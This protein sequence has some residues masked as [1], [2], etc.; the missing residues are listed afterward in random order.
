MEDWIGGQARKP[1]APPVPSGNFTPKKKQHTSNDKSA[2]QPKSPLI[3]MMHAFKKCNLKKKFRIFK[4]KQPRSGRGS[5]SSPR[6][7]TP[8]Q[9]SKTATANPAS[10][11]KENTEEETTADD[12]IST[13]EVS[14]AS[15]SVAQGK[16]LLVKDK[17]RRVSRSNRHLTRPLSATMSTGQ[18]NMLKSESETETEEEEED[19]PPETISWKSSE[20]QKNAKDAINRCTIPFIPQVKTVSNVPG[21]SGEK[22][23]VKRNLMSQF[24]NS[25][26]SDKEN[27]VHTI[28]NNSTWDEDDL[29][30]GHFI[31]TDNSNSDSEK[32]P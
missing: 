4:R 13:G 5:V 30:T 11:K 23:P 25:E 26:V 28:S 10:K 1:Q 22:F 14:S 6:K 16:P 20:L 15:A 24:E 27:S 7:K 8:E 18:R 32:R 12:A 17:K 2:N 29:E 3:K 21:T 19:Q 31:P 9:N